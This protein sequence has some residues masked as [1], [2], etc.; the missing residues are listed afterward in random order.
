M[1]T[2]KDTGIFALFII[3]VLMAGGLM[4]LWGQHNSAEQ[5]FEVGFLHYQVAEQ[6]VHDTDY[7]FTEEEQ[8]RVDELK[9]TALKSLERKKH[10]EGTYTT[11][12]A[13]AVFGDFARVELPY[14]VY[15]ENNPWCV[16]LLHGYNETPED[17]APEAAWWLKQGYQVILPALRGHG[18]AVEASAFGVFEQYDL[19]DLLCTLGKDQRAV[20]VHGRGVGAAAA[21]LLAANESYP[22]MIH[23]IVADSVY[24][25]LQTLKSEQLKKQFGLGETLVGKMLTDI[26][27]K[28]LG[29]DLTTVSIAEAAAQSPMV[30]KLFVCGGADGFV[31]PEHTQAVYEAAGETANLLEIEG[32]RH[33]LCWLTSGGREGEYAAAIRRYI[34][35]NQ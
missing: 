16:V 28:Q 21:L 14:T 17:M 12:T 23:G 4:L 3:G 20:R 7:A 6:L 10:A 13:A 2:K 34:I 31:P 15:G 18:G 29:F 33:R 27:K 24:S 8:A 30:P 5:V 19:Y 11:D 35:G 26:V 22:T 9:E 32:A 1:K 25:D